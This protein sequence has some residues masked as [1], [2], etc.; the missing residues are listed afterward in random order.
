[1]RVARTSRDEPRGGPTLTW[2]PILAIIVYNNLI[3]SGRR[4]ST[5]RRRLP[6]VGDCARSLDAYSAL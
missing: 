2:D 5:V 1:M 3:C 4:D 6:K